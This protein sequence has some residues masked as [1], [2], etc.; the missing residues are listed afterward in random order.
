V[1]PTESTR[2]SCDLARRVGRCK[3]RREGVADEIERSP[4]LAVPRALADVVRCVGEVGAVLSV[5]IGDVRP[6]FDRLRDMAG[7]HETREFD[8]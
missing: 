2:H 5:F 7:T 6:A 8:R 3:E 1:A 4:H